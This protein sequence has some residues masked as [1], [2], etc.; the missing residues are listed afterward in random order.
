ACSQQPPDQGSAGFHRFRQP[1]QRKR[2]VIGIS[3]PC[4]VHERRGSMAPSFFICRSSLFAACNAGHALLRVRPSAHSGLQRCAFRLKSSFSILP[5]GASTPSTRLWFCRFSLRVP[6]LILSP[7][8]GF[9]LRPDQGSSVVEFAA[10]VTAFRHG[11]PAWMSHYSS[12]SRQ[13][14]KPSKHTSLH[15]LPASV[16]PRLNEKRL[17]GCNIPAA[18]LVPAA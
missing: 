5:F 17:Q 14:W 15:L 8:A 9:S 13:R 16:T 11:K 7:L 1:A 3:A 4:G 10:A 2:P 18:V 12:K 6:K